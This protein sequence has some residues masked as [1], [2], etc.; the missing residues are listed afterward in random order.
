MAT[1]EVPLFQALAVVQQLNVTVYRSEWSAVLGR[2]A[3]SQDLAGLPSMPL[4]YRWT[5][6]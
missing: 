1:A 2:E 5:P 4:E 6:T 3:H